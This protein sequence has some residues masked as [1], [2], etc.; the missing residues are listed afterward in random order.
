MDLIPGSINYI[1]DDCL[2]ITRINKYFNIIIC[3]N[4]FHLISYDDIYN[5]LK[6]LK[7]FLSPNG[8]ILIIDY[9]TS[10]KYANL[11]SLLL[12]LYD[13]NYRILDFK[14]IK[15]ILSKLD[16]VIKDEIKIKNYRQKL[17][18]CSKK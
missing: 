14:K 8:E 16:I 4:I 15:K 12:N 11:F 1:Q 5:L 2:K 6:T 13:K 10:D 7:N 3:S 9:F 17:V 18:L